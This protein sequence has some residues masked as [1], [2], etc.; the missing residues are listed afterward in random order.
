MKN[1]IKKLVVILIIFMM[2]ITDFLFVG[3]N[4]SYAIDFTEISNENVLMSAYFVNSDNEKVTNI[5]AAINSTDLKLVIEITVKNDNKL[6][7]YFSGNITLDNAN[8]KLIDEI[9]DIYVAS[10]ETK[11]IERKIEFLENDNLTSTYLSQ[12]SK[13]VLNGIYV[14]SKKTYNIN[15][16]VNAQVNWVIPEDYGA[17]FSMK[18]LTN[19]IYKINDKDRRVVQLLVASKIKDNIYPVKNTEFVIDGIDGVE[20]VKVHKRTTNATNGNKDISDGSYSYEGENGKLKINLENNEENGKISWEKDCFDV[21]VVTYIF[22]ENAEFSEAN[23]NGE[24]NITAYDETK[25]S[26]N[27][28]INVKDEIDGIITNNIIESEESIYKGN[29]YA[30]QK[31]NISSTTA[32][33]I[34]YIDTVENMQINEYASLLLAGDEEKDTNITFSK[35]IVAADELK[36]IFGEDGSIS[37]LDREG[38]VLG[39]IKSTDEAN[40]N[41]ELVFEYEGDFNEIIILAD[42]PIQ[43]GIL[44]IKHEKIINETSLSRDDIRSL[45]GIKETSDIIY[46]K[47]DGNVRKNSTQKIINLL[48]TESKISV[49]IDND[50]L[51]TTAENQTLNMNITLETNNETNDLYKNPHI[52]VIFPKQIKGLKINY[53]MIQTDE[54][55][56]NKTNTK[57]KEIDGCLVLDM[58]IDGEETKYANDPF[59]GGV[60]TLAISDIVIDKYV[61]SSTEDIIIEFGNEN[62]INLYNNGKVNKSINIISESSLIYTHDTNDITTY[63]DEGKKVIELNIGEEKTEKITSR[64]IN[65]EKSTISDVKILGQIPIKEEQ[66]KRTS[67]INVNKDAKIYY[68]TNENPTVDLEDISNGWTEENNENARY[69]LIKIDNMENAEEILVTYDLKITKDIDYNTY[70]ESKYTI[71]YIP[72]A[73]NN[74]VQYTSSI[75]CFSTGT[76]AVLENSVKTV[77]GNDILEDGAEVKAGEIIKYVVDIKN[78]GTED[79]KDVSIIANIPEELTLLEINK[80]YTY[81]EMYDERDPSEIPD[82][83]FLEKEGKEE[84]IENI[85]VKSGES[86]KYEI[87]AKVNKITNDITGK[88]DILINYKDETIDTYQINHLFKKSDLSILMRPSGRFETEILKSRATYSYFLDVTNTSENDKE[89]VKVKISSNDIMEISSILYMQDE[90]EI[91]GDISQKEITIEKIKSGE[92]ICIIV[93]AKIGL[94]TDEIEYTNI[95]A[96]IDD[97]NIRSN[98]VKEKVE[99]IDIKAQIEAKV[100]K[101]TGYLEPGDKITYSI[102]LENIG[103]KDANDIKIEDYFSTYLDI[104]SIALDGEKYDYE[105]SVVIGENYDL[106]NIITSLNK[107]ETKEF[108]ISAEVNSWIAS[109]EEINIINKANIYDNESMLLA[110]IEA[111]SYKVEPKEDL[112]GTADPIE[113][114]EQLAPWEKE[115]GDDESGSLNNETDKYRVSG[116]IWLDENK[117]GGKDDEEKNIEGISVYAVNINTN[118]IQKSDGNIILATTNSDGYYTLELPAG[119]YVIVFEYDTLK[120]NITSYKAENITDNNN[121]K[122]IKQSLSLDGINKDVAVTDTIYLDTNY[123]NINL[124]LTQYNNYNLKIEKYVSKIVVTNKKGTKTY[125][126]KDGQT[127]AKVEIGSKVLNG[128]NVVIEYAIKITNNGSNACYAKSVKDYLPKE[129]DF[130]SELNQDWYVSGE[131]L[132]NNSLSN[133]LINPD[134]T[135]ELKLILTKTMTSSNTGLINNRAE[136]A[137]T[138]GV[139][140]SDEDDSDNI[141]SADV[142][143]GIKTGGVMIALYTF[144]IIAI[145]IGLGYL[146]NKKILKINFKERR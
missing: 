29:L 72:L 91:A 139:N 119:N 137:E 118:E 100:D 125:E 81:N 41:G 97:N 60:I 15:G 59:K 131:E 111:N 9:N 79:A 7:G 28:M 76:S 143:L 114:I 120:Y 141:A 1:I 134:E 103:K 38:K 78:N 19:Y 115:E 73:T 98:V 12:V 86:V 66:I 26:A 127:L 95:Y 144:L 53:D 108:I 45:T 4:L 132:Y 34:D 46:E 3:I 84:K 75:L 51:S 69:Y 10:G 99:G 6:G 54:L 124:G 21:I 2:Q 8:F 129:L 64:I 27:D 58:M 110:E 109:S 16:S 128:T 101:Q 39:N 106:I 133:I 146:I 122:A 77:V 80:D 35:T 92:T 24:V 140:G 55:S 82:G 102:K 11:V 126:Q 123:A 112:S 70:E 47:A 32:I 105:K 42:K 52:K 94:P 71:S 23:L 113:D 17:M 48:E 104:I 31:R 83:Y 13:V 90:N 14:N 61:A 5:N 142:I 44:N 117:N 116:I 68:T 50:N 33:N 22:E 25:L 57:I 135:K 56:I 93:D 96:I 130:S 89:N 62:A 145:L 18:V 67:Q 88:T 85:Y 121:S 43:K 138:Y 87:I 63:L 20:T 136:I 37:I 107:G 65:N 30:K 49:D 74:L 36:K 40:E